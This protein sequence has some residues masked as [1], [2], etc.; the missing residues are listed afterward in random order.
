MFRRRGLALETNIELLM[1]SLFDFLSTLEFRPCLLNRRNWLNISKKG[2]WL[3]VGGRCATV[4]LSPKGHQ[5]SIGL[6]ARA[7]A[8]GPGAG[9]FGKPSGPANA[10][11][12]AVTVAHVVYLILI[13]LVILWI[14]A[15]KDA[16]TFTKSESHNFANLSHRVQSDRR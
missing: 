14:L 4:N 13:A 16:E 8:I 2:G 7:S 11:H 5:E 6:L 15:G 9:S 3:G 12:G 1:E 10:P